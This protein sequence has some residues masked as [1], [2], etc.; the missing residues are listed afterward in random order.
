MGNRLDTDS[1]D[2]ARHGHPY[3]ISTSIELARKQATSP[4]VR[5]PP[6]R[7]LPAQVATLSISL[8]SYNFSPQHVAMCWI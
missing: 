3:I 6:T 5:R 1:V 7:Q 2:P 8:T 4:P